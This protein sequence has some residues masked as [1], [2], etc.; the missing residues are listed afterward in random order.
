MAKQLS[1]VALAE[2]RALRLTLCV[3][4][5]GL[6]AA[7]RDATP[8][9]P[10]SE[11]VSFRSDMDLGREILG[12]QREDTDSDGAD[13]WIVF[14]R[15]DQVGKGG[16]VAAI[17]YDAAID[18]ASQL[19]VLYPFKLRTPDQNYLAELVPKVTLVNILTEGNGKPLNELV[20]STERELAIF[21]LSR[22]PAI[23]PTDNPPLYRCVGFFRSDRVSFDPA[24]FQVVVTSFAGF[25]RSQ[26]VTKRYFKPDNSASADG[27]FVAGTT[28]PLNPYDYEVDFREPVNEKILDT[29]YPE[30]ILLAFYQ[31][32]GRADAKPTAVEYLSTQA[33]AEFRAGRLRIGSPFGLD[34]VRRATVKR[35]S[36]F[37][38]QDTDTSARVIAEVVFTSRA[39]QQSNPVEVTWVLQRTDSRWRLHAL[40]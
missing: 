8:A 9:E 34:Q 27:Y 37:P 7:C 36:Y 26:L 16:P 6:L 22:D 11:M 1:R 33:A 24:T 29:P 25:E 14:Y 18:T 32:L 30:K 23:P 10:R 40:E 12:V 4:L 20:F 19:P 3:I 38:T 2:N 31:S 35:I 5:M 15:F 21:R 28:T 39:G 17:V 13:E